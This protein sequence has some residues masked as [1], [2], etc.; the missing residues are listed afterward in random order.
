MRQIE[1]SMW[2]NEQAIISSSVVLFGGI[3]GITGFFRA[4]EIGIYAVY[5][6]LVVAVLVFVIEYPR[7][8]RA[9]G[10][11]TER[12]LCAPLCFILATIMGGL[13]LFVTSMIYLVAA[14]K[15]EQWSPVGLEEKPVEDNK[16]ELKSFR[17]PKKPPPRAPPQGIE[18]NH[19]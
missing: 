18:D 14:F 6:F 16:K 15:G 19:I 8:K 13:C 9:K 7:G 1:W 4:W 2:A 17:Q 10:R 11:T 5:P 12:K 3:I